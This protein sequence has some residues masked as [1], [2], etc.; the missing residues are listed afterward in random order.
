MFCFI[1][2]F[3]IP[4]SGF[5]IPDFDFRIPGF[6]VARQEIVDPTKTIAAAYSQQS[7]GDVELSGKANAGTQCVAIFL[8][9]LIYNLRNLITSSADLVQMMNNGN[10]MYKTLPQSCKQGFL[11]LTDLPVMVNLSDI[12]Y[13]LT[14]SESCSGLLNGVPHIIADFPYVT[15]LLAAFILCS[16]IIIMYLF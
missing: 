1:F 14:C 9:A 15:S 5:R 2:G 6:R 13:Q 7:Q 10:N 12:N 11:L 16:W 4:D 3:R 8:S